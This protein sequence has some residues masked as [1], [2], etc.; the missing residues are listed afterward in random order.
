ML[1]WTFVTP[2]FAK[3][4]LVVIS[5]FFVVHIRSPSPITD[6]TYARSSGR[7]ESSEGPK[8]YSH[9]DRSWGAGSGFHRVPHLVGIGAGGS[10][11]S[12]WR[13]IVPAGA[14]P[15]KDPTAF[16]MPS[17]FEPPIIPL[18]DGSGRIGPRSFFV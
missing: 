3:E 2:A 5:L 17:A 6:T 10:K 4:P 13:I 8:V 7:V 1:L 12:A 18:A 14:P 16:R 9:P 11:L 15:A